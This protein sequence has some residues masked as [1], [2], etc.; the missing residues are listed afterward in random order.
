MFESNDTFVEQVVKARSTAKDNLPR[1]IFIALS[2][3]SLLLSVVIPFLSAIFVFFIVMTYVFWANNHEYEYDYTNGSLVIAKITNNSK[4]KVIASVESSEVKMVAAVGTNEALRYDHLNLKTVDC[5]A[6][7][8][9]VKNYVLVAHD[10]K[11]N[12]DYKIVFNPNEKLLNAM[13]RYNRHEI[14]E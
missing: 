11:K 5:S 9:K 7:D 3:V 10:D 8:E 14:F 1:Y 13:K 2:I 4:R 6:H 12:C